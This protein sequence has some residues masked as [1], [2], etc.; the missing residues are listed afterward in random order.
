MIPNQSQAT[1]NSRTLCL[2]LLYTIIA[3][4]YLL[5][6]VPSRRTP[7]VTVLNQRGRPHHATPSALRRCLAPVRHRATSAS[8]LRRHCAA[9]APATASPRTAA[10]MG[11]HCCADATPLLRHCG[12]DGPPLLRQCCA[13]P[14]PRHYTATTP[15]QPEC[16]SAALLLTATLLLY[17]TTLRYCATRLLVLYVILYIDM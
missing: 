11:R 4:N 13:P 17:C 12:A 5:P 1:S 10:P 6:P 14:L 7:A 8:P 3:F 2:I 15:A 16:G 9:T